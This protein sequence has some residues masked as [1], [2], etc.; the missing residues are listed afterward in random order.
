MSCS[1]CEEE[2]GRAELNGQDIFCHFGRLSTSNFRDDVR[3]HT[4]VK[5]LQLSISGSRISPWILYSKRLTAV[6]RALQY[7]IIGILHKYRGS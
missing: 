4:S 3:K 2:R 1:P 6:A 7:E 5:T